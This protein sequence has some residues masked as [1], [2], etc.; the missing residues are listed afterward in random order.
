MIL[1]LA[2]H[3]RGFPKELPVSALNIGQ[4]FVQG[5]AE[6]GIAEDSETKQLH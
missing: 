1:V 4:S 6:E 3:K 5:I 2:I